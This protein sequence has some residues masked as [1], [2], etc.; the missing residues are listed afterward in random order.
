MRDPALMFG[1]LLRLFLRLFTSLALARVARRLYRDETCPF[2]RV[3]IIEDR[4]VIE[5]AADDVILVE[6]LGD[7]D[8]VRQVIRLRARLRLSKS[9]IAANQIDL[10]LRVALQNLVNPARFFRR[11]AGFARAGLEIQFSDLVE[12]NDEPLRQFVDKSRR[13]ASNDSISAS[14]APY[15]QMPLTRSFRC[16]T[17]C[18]SPLTPSR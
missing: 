1:L 16:A 4:R 10:A 8:R 7:P 3:E 5:S 12:P 14:I 11:A 6:L 15:F 2:E 17:S 18:P 13:V 9:A